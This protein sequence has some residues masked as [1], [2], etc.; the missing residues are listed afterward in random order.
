ML[1]RRRGAAPGAR[2]LCPHNRR[3][4]G[5][6]QSLAPAHPAGLGGRGPLRLRTL[7]GWEPTVPCA[8]APQPAVGR[9][10]LVTV[11]S[12]SPRVRAWTSMAA[13][14]R[15]AGQAALARGGRAG[16]PPPQPPCPSPSRPMGELRPAARF[17]ALGPST[18]PVPG[19]HRRA[20]MPMTLAVGVYWKLKQWGNQLRPQTRGAYALRP[21]ATTGRGFP[22]PGGPSPASRR[23]L[24]ICSRNLA[25]ACPPGDRGQAAGPSR[26]RLLCPAR[27]RGPHHAL[28]CARRPATTAI[29]AEAPQASPFSLQEAL[30]AGSAPGY[31]A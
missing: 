27:W 25:C 8:C 13:R 16:R 17:W 18:C 5:T 3:W 19:S 15:A 29:I 9:P 31:G 14:P 6:L 2:A 20:S 30:P 11:F 26:P 10:G 1:L 24:P 28:A 23:T 12:P 4:A 7:L 21:G 22:G